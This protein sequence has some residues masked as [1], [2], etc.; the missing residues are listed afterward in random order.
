[1]FCFAGYKTI[2]ENAVKFNYFNMLR[3]NIFCVARLVI[4][5][6]AQSSQFINNINQFLE[7]FFTSH[8]KGLF[9]FFDGGKLLDGQYFILQK[10]VNS[11]IV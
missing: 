1:M 6:E 8:E 7:N 3:D 9:D 2:P 5:K 11:G 10:R 4:L